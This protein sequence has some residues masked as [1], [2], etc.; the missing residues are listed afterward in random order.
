MEK[1][2]IRKE[3]FKLKIKGHTGVIIFS[4]LVKEVL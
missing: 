4:E 3:Y 1:E 2:L